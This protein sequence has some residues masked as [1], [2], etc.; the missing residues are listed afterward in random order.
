MGHKKAGCDGYTNGDAAGIHSSAP[1]AM[2]IVVVEVISCTYH[3][4]RATF[5][6]DFSKSQKSHSQQR[7][8]GPRPNPPRLLTKTQYVVAA[9]QR[10]EGEHGAA[11]H[12]WELDRAHRS[13]VPNLRGGDA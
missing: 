10:G 7:Q 2:S 8:L 11:A 6:A 1:A 3:K 9:A 12:E 13:A 4:N 5:L